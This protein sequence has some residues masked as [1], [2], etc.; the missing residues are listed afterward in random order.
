MRTPCEILR[1]HNL[2]PWE[3]V[4]IKSRME[5]IYVIVSSL[6]ITTYLQPP[7]AHQPAS[8]EFLEE[9][10]SCTPNQQAPKSFAAALDRSEKKR[11]GFPWQVPADLL[12]KWCIDVPWSH[13][14]HTNIVLCPFAGQVSSELVHSSF[15]YAVHYTSVNNLVACWDWW[16][17][18]YTGT[19]SGFQERMTQ[20]WTMYKTG[21]KTLTV[22]SSKHIFAGKPF[23]NKPCTRKKKQGTAASIRWT[24]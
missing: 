12:R 10:Y 19:F 6:N 1:E 22:A 16:Q 9:P 23:S 17:E 5:D 13:G 20:L 7:L 11:S 24:F 8:W 4:I 3:A 14:V 18:H 15:W 2:E 21:C